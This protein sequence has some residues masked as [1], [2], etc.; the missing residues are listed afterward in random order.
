M[1]SGGGLCVGLI[2][3]QRSYT[4]CGVS[5]CDYVAS[6]MRRPSPKRGCRAMEKRNPIKSVKTE[7]ADDGA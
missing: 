4:E 1:L 7:G 5:E 6:T 2:T 3:V